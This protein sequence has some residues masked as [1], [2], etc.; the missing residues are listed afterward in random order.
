MHLLIQPSAV[1]VYCSF[2]PD[3]P[4]DVLSKVN[5]GKVPVH[6]EVL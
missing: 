2:Y 1:V 3:I 6:F 5:L 4:H